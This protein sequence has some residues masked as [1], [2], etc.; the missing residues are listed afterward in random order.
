LSIETDPEPEIVTPPAIPVPT[1]LPTAD[2]APQA[3]GY[4]ISSTRTFPMRVPVRTLPCEVTLHP[5]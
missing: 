5:I 4:R 1:R 2:C 3:I